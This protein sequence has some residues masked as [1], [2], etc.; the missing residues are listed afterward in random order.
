MGIATGG[1]RL[2]PLSPAF[3]PWDPL[4]VRRARGHHVLTSVEV[5][6]TELCNLRCAHCAVGAQLAPRERHRLPADLIIR[7]LDE[8][9]T[10]ETF[11]VTGGE[12]LVSPEVVHE[13]VA[14]LL[15]YARRRG[16]RTQ[17]LSSPM[18]RRRR[19]RIPDG[20]STSAS[21]ITSRGWPGW[22]RSS[23]PRR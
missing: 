6:V 17:I 13:L 14:P 7:R 15:R 23:R 19:P 10:L 3:D 21:W 4:P 16:L 5:T 11:S 8:V 2:R 18:Q 20:A 12:P 9:D 1:E 22:A